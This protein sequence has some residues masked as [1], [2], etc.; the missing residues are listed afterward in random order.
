MTKT[1]VVKKLAAN[2]TESCDLTQNQ[3]SEILNAILSI[4]MEGLKTDGQVQLTG[5]CTMKAKNV[6]EHEGHNPRNPEEKITIP[7]RVQ[8]SFTAGAN[9]KDYLNK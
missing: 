1:D 9:L 6:P 4:I 2:G 8:V 3:A 7:S 5:F